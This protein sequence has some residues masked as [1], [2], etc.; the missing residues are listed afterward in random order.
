MVDACTQAP[1]VDIKEANAKKA[2]EHQCFVEMA[3]FD[4]TRDKNP[5]FK[6]MRQYMRM[7]PG[8]T[9]PMVGYRGAAEGFTS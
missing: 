9:L 7:V 8:S 3:E 1:N 4:I 6:V 5:L 2:V